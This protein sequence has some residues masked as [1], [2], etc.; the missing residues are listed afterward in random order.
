MKIEFIGFKK[1]HIKEIKKKLSKDL[2][3]LKTKKT[4]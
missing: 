3:K 1:S 4:K 2:K